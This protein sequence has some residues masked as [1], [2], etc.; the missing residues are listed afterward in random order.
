MSRKP[1]LTP[2][3]IWGVAPVGFLGAGIASWQATGSY[4][5]AAGYGIAFVAV[6]VAAAFAYRR[7]RLNS[8]Q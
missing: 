3:Q 2:K 8:G 4:L 5:E 1:V 6:Y 7:Y